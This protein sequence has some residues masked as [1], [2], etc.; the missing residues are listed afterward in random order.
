M[1]SVCLFLNKTASYFLV[2]INCESFFLLSAQTGNELFYT[3]PRR[4]YMRLVVPSEEQQR[5]VLE[6]CHYN[7]VT[8][9]H[10]GMRSTRDRVIAGY[11]WATINKDVADWVKHV[12]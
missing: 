7:P 1:F 8:G 5:D 11:Y 3:G 6:A 4:Q 10:N 2:Y 12:A 9:N